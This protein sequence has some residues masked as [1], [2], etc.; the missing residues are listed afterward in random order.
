MKSKLSNLG[1]VASEADACLFISPNI[2]C[3]LYVDDSKFV[4]RDQS[5]MDDLVKRMDHEGKLFNEKT[6]ST[7]NKRTD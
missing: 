6:Y 5:H 3:F 1:F 7:R 4:Y 2:I